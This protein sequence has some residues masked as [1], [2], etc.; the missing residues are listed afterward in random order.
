VEKDVQGCAS[1]KTTSMSWARKRMRRCMVS[2]AI[3]VGGLF[4]RLPSRHPEILVRDSRGKSLDS[5]QIPEILA[6][7]L[8]ILEENLI[9]K[10]ELTTIIY[11]F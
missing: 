3:F 8:W 1:V 7:N 11:R 4:I 5:I 10:R 9:G 2:E 6:E